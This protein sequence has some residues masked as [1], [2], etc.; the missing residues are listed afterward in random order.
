MVYIYYYYDSIRSV[1]NNSA[2]FDKWNPINWFNDYSSSGISSHT[3]EYE[4]TYF[5]MSALLT[6]AC[7]THA[8]YSY[9]RNIGEKKIKKITLYY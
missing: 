1:Y 2:M 3:F 8:D 5:R 9:F 6:V 4:I 7:G